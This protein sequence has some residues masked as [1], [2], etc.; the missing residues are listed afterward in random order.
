MIRDC[1]AKEISKAGISHVAVEQTAPD[2]TTAALR[3]D[4]CY[5]DSR[6]RAIFLDVEV[7]T[8]HVHKNTS[9]LRACALI[10]LADA[11]KK[12]K[13][14]HVRLLPSMFSHLGKVGPGYES[15]YQ[16][17]LPGP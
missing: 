2:D 15:M 4:I 13:Y 17:N 10:E 5:H 9:N 7:T 11:V 14:A 16:V 12:R 1:T 6:S 3:P 8:R